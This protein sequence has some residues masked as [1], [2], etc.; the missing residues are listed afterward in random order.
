[1]ITHS[2]AEGRARSLALLDKARWLPPLVTRVTLGVLFLST[3]WSKLHDLDKVTGFFTELGIPAPAFNA[4][5][6]AY[7]ETICGI[8][9]LL[10]LATR[11]ACVPLFI[12]MVVATVTAKLGQVHSLPD[13]FG[14]V[15]FTYLGLLLFIGVYGPGAFSVD[16]A[17]ARALEQHVATAPARRVESPFFRPLRHRHA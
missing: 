6:V 2:L 4:T 7:T 9:L 15:E 16:V 13:L 11:L 5:L 1:M 14:L 3:G 17:I 10:G 12:T 8:L